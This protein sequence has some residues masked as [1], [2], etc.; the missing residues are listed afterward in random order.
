MVT[1]RL[2]TEEDVPGIGRLIADTYSQYNLSFLPE[3][4]VGLFLGPFQHAYSDDPEHIQAIADVVASEIVLVAEA[5]TGEIVGVL[6]GRKER[7]A[8]LFVRGDYQRQGIGRKLVERFEQESI[9]MG[10]KVIRLAAT[11]YAVPFY[12][13][14]GYKRS[15]GVRIGWSFEGR[16]LPNQPMRKVLDTS[17]PVL[18]RETEL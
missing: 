3:E 9:K 1:I 15:T 5:D 13:A 12:A 11:M 4:H 17:Q 8:S 18:L 10:A 14:M 16:G 6:R 7:L 2:Y